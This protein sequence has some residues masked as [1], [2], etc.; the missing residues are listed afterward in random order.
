MGQAS[1]RSHWKTLPG[2][3]HS[4]PSVWQESLLPMA[5]TPCRSSQ[6]CNLEETFS[7][8][9]NRVGS[10]PTLSEASAFFPGLKL[11]QLTLPG[12]H[13]VN[14]SGLSFLSGLSLLSELDL[15]DY[16]QVT[17]Q[18]VQ[19]LSNM[20]RSGCTSSTSHIT[21]VLHVVSLHLGYWWVFSV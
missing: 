2:S 19:Q 3:L 11:T 7:N 18:G 13:S 17:D 1:Q 9:G 12:R 5:T 16:T 4:L 14:N 10:N 21:A 6:V 20:T 8:K 15:T